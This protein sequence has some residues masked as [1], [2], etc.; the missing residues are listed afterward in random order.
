MFLLV[1]WLAA[2]VPVG[3]NAP[4]PLTD[5]PAVVAPATQASVEQEYFPLDTRTGLGE[6]DRILAVV[7]SNDLHGLRD[8]LGF[9]TT[10]CTTAD[11]LGGPP[12]CLV[13][14]ADGALVDVLPFLGGEGSFIR[15]ADI[16][17][18]QGIDVSRLY[19]V[20]KVSESAYS[21]EYIPAG[22]YAIMFVAPDNMPGVVLQVRNG[23][24][25]RIDNVFDESSRAATLQR[26][27]SEL[28]LA[29]PSQK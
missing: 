28:I 8:L 11:G 14:E 7:E 23:K 5:E 2:C 18:W 3:N 29:P 22:E 27:A 24:I 10:A 4:K 17:D 16:N 26:D 13:D 9:T 21:E 1:F 12:K 20:Y 15:K 19:A 6:I 25:I